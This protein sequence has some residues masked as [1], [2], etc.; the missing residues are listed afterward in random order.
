MRWRLSRRTR[1]MHGCNPV[2][3]SECPGQRTR[4]KSRG[5]NKEDRQETGDKPS[6]VFPNYTA[7]EQRFERMERQ[8]SNCQP[9]I[10]DP[11]HQFRRCTGP[12]Q[13]IGVRHVV[14]DSLSKR[15][16]R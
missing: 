10:K 12:G 1:R 16:L 4:A 5:D 11:G 7:S 14:N 15:I 13:N 3:T 8:M 2:I 9:T 6:Q